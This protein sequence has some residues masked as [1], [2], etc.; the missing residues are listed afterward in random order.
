MPKQLKHGEPNI[1]EMTAEEALES[2]E[3]ISKFGPYGRQL[4]NEER[5]AK[6][7]YMLEETI[8]CLYEEIERQRQE[9]EDA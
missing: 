8:T 4:T 2:I 7:V 1:L 3:E 6:Q 5:R 9:K